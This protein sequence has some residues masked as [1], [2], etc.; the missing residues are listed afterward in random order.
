[1]D[2]NLFRRFFELVMA[3]LLRVVIGK[4]RVLERLATLRTLD[5]LLKRWQRGEHPDSVE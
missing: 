3:A 5:A 1:M 4:R 2:P